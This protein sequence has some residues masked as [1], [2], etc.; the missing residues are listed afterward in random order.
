MP[1][2]QIKS[3]T[4]TGRSDSNQNR[5]DRLSDANPTQQPEDL[6]V[7][8]GNDYDAEIRKGNITSIKTGKN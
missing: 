7:I 2:S 3:R 5:K 6:A 4:K 1:N 8:K